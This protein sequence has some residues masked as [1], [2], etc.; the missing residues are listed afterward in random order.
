MDKKLQNFR[1][2]YFPELEVES[3]GSNIV[4]GVAASYYGV[5]NVGA[6]FHR[7][8]YEKGGDFPDF[9]LKLVLKACSKKFGQERF[10]IVVYVPPTS[11]GDLVKNF[12]IKVSQVLK[13]PI[14]HNLVKCKNTKEQKTFENGYL[15]T[16]NVS[17]AFTFTTP[18]DIK[19]M[20]ILLIYDVFDSGATVKEVGR[21]LTN[22][23]AVKIAPIVIARTVGGDLVK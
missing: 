21:L 1:E 7:A 11:S 12:A 6:A 19:G 15:K 16:D 14:S 3:K 20:S 22:Y 5:S 9:L 10:D 17:C 23:G 2:D 4:N 18:N 8:K 13:L